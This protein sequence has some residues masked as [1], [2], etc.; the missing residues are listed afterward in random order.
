M[1]RMAK[2]QLESCLTL[3]FRD[4]P[5]VLCSDSYNATEAIVGL[6]TCRF[7]VGRVAQGVFLSIH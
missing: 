1:A 6:L 5:I 7:R 3:M 4:V 2:D